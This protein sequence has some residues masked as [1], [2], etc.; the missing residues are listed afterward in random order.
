MIGSCVRSTELRLASDSA[1]DKQRTRCFHARCVP[2]FPAAMTMLIMAAPSFASEPPD[3]PNA[4]RL[5]Q[6]VKKLSTVGSV[7]YVAAHPDDENTNLLAYLAN[8]K[9]LRAAYLSITRGDG[10]Q[11]LIGAEQSEELGLLRTQELLAARRIDGAEQLFTR[12]KDFGFSKTPEETL[13]IWGKDEIL[14]DVV[15]AIRTFRPDVVITRFPQDHDEGQHGHHTAS[16]RLALEAFRAAADPAFHP[17]QLAHV[18][19]W[20]ARRIVWNKSLF[21][22]KPN[23]DLSSFIKLEAPAYNPL[24]GLS[25][26]EMAAESRSMHKSQGFGVPKSRGPIIEYFKVLDGEPAQTDIFEGIDFSWRRFDKSGSIAQIS[27]RIDKELAPEAPERSIPALLELD[28]A[29]DDLGDDGWRALKR[30]DVHELIAACAG[31]FVEAAASEPTAAPGGEWK[32]AIT[33][34]NRSSAALELDRVA[35]STGGSPPST[36]AVSK[37]LARGRAEQIE[38]SLPIPASAPYSQP[39][40]LENKAEP[41]RFVVTDPRMIGL[42]ENPP[43]LIAEIFLSSGGRRFSI[44]RPGIF[45]WTDPVAGERRR[46]LEILP[47]VSIAPDSPVLIFTDERP[48]DLRVVI[49]SHAPRATGSVVFEGAGG[50]EIAPAPGTVCSNDRASRLSCG[51]A[52]DGKDAETELLVRISSHSRD[53]ATLSIGPIPS[54]STRTALDAARTARVDH[55]EHAHIPIQLRMSASEVR[56]VPVDLRR[57]GDRIGYIPGAGDEVA[58]SLERAGYRVTIL[59]EEELRTGSLSKLDAIVTGVRAFN[60]NPHLSRHR[61]KLLDWVAKGGTLVVQ[62]NTNNRLAKIESEIGPWPFEIARDRVTD[63]KAEV[64]FELPKHPILHRPNEITA[65]EF[66]GWIQERGLYFAGKW[67][68]RYAA[69][70]SMHD[71]NEAPTKGSLLVAKHGSGKFVY[72]GLAFFRQLPRGVPG[73][74]KLFANLIA[75]SPHGR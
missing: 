11:N 32:L 41:G 33:A 67:D 70:L 1:R 38:H 9:H 27:A 55:I 8:E 53:P 56:L 69:P 68:P 43:A 17:E 25:Y 60:T 6:A 63:E 15:W 26:G 23:E 24:L 3:Q 71:P 52:L 59:T 66:E 5:A 62:Y 35:L 16:A 21:F 39:Y 22:V 30:R 36:I 42:P 73:A 75:R 45:K 13:A 47:P 48:R 46:P 58:R 44:S 18:K 7:L 29:L 74:Y 57:D 31:L 10:G 14:A 37:P 54:G 50:F 2:G 51:F 4:G 65:Q 19:P 64:S 28:R 34:L 12:A 49:K 20:R 61:A 40:W 72:T